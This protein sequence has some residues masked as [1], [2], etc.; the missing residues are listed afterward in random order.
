MQLRLASKSNATDDVV[1]FEW[2]PSEP[3]TWL[4]GQFMKYTLPHENA[5]DRGTSRWFTIAAPPFAGKPRITTR[6][7]AEKGSSF[8]TALMSMQVGATIEASRPSGDFI[9]EDPRR[10]LVL[11]AGGIGV[12][13]YRAIL[14]QLDHDGVHITGRL[15]Y[16]NRNDQYIFRDEFES[17]AARHANFAVRYFTSPKHIELAD[18]QA[19]ARELENPL[20][21][22]SGPE[23]MVEQYK[24]MLVGAGITEANIKADYFPG[25]GTI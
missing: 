18:I 22:L 10:Q 24:E 2:E 13:P 11:V 4:A 14:E 19:N 17:L 6:I 20:Y 15:L 7:T 23:P 3:M 25:Y 5:D 1:T 21:Y 12:T 9:V 16:A 8:K